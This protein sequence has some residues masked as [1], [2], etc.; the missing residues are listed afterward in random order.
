VGQF[1]ASRTRRALSTCVRP[2]CVHKRSNI[3]PQYDSTLTAHSHT[4]SAYTTGSRGISSFSVSRI[5]CSSKGSQSNDSNSDSKIDSDSDSPVSGVPVSTNRSLLD[6]LE[7]EDVDVFVAPEQPR[8]SVAMSNLHRA[9]ESGESEAKV[10]PEWEVLLG[11]SQDSLYINIDAITSEDEIWNHPRLSAGNKLSYA[12]LWRAKNGFGPP[13]SQSESPDLRQVGEQAARAAQE[14]MAEGRRQ[15][16]EEMKKN[17][18]DVPDGVLLPS[19]QYLK[20]SKWRLPI[21]YSKIPEEMWNTDSSDWGKKA[22]VERRK[23]EQSYASE[24][25]KKFHNKHTASGFVEEDEEVRSHRLEEIATR[26]GY[27]GISWLTRGYVRVAFGL[28]LGCFL[29]FL[30]FSMLAPLVRSTMRAQTVLHEAHDTR[31]DRET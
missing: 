16:E 29:A 20:G 2:R 3:A 5:V 4:H 14:T 24:G 9:R 17:M 15:H 26:K 28:V 10:N 18:V 7:A 25:W 21:D 27:L 23:I 30:L 8:S 19:D 11:G 1:V 12:Q 13:G 31:R 6:R 22:D